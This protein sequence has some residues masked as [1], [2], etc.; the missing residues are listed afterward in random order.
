MCSRQLT[1]EALDSVRHT[2]S[3][4]NGWHSTTCET[5][6]HSHLTYP[7]ITGQPVTVSN[8]NIYKQPHSKKIIIVWTTG[9]IRL[10][11]PNLVTWASYSN[12]IR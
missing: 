6:F 11:H 9:H 4:L 1:D 10:G 12:K 7:K 2:T 8:F 5:F 3:I